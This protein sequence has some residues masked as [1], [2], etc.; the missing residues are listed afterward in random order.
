MNLFAHFQRVALD[1]ITALMAEG[2]LPEGLDLSKVTVEPPRDAVAWRYRDQCGDGAGQ[3]RRP[4]AAG[5]CRDAERAAARACRYR[6]ARS[7]ARASS[8]SRLKPSFWPKLMASAL[9][10][11]DAYGRSTMGQ[12]LKVNVEYVSANPTGPLHVGHCRGAVFGDALATLLSET[13]HAV[14]KEYYINDAGAQ[15]DMLARSA[16]PALSRGAGRNDRRDSRRPLSRRLSEAGGR[17]AGRTSTARRCSTMPEEVWLPIVR[18]KAVAMMMDLMRDDLAALNIRHE[19]FFSEK[20]LHESGAIAETVEGLRE[21]GQSM[22]AACRRPR[23]AKCRRAGKIASSCCSAPAPSATISTGRSSKSDG[24]FTYFAADIAYSR[25]QDRARLQGARLCAGCRSRRLREAAGGHRRGACRQGEVKVVVRLCQLVKLFRGGEPVRMSKRA[26]EFVTLRE[27]VDE[28]GAD[29]VRFIMLYRK[30]EAPLDFDFK[31]VTEQ[32]KD[33][34][35]FYVQYAHAR[36]CSVFRKRRRQPRLNSPG[37]TFRGFGDPG[38]IAVI[39]RVAEYPRH[40][41]SC[42]RSS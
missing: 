25:V 12:G 7:P 28:V 2:A 14:T 35:V 13:G 8:I 34:P 40:G 17:G 21:A 42:R 31:K 22:R 1:A 41:R 3:A 9:A 6:R 11:G 24:T 16:Y 20:S 26:G 36:I 10:L 30:N 32:S 15:I 4:Q 29:V 23:A 39:R 5:A 38:E 19:V 37:A 27:V 33:N 18:D